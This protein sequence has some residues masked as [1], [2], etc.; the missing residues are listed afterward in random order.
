ML[1][2]V[3]SLVELDVQGRQKQ[4]RKHTRYLSH[5]SLYLLTLDIVSEVIFSFTSSPLPGGS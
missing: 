5:L 4:E 3:I 1:S 2:L